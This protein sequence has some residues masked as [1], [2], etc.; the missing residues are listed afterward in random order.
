MKNR[1]LLVLLAVV[2]VVSLIAF[3]ACKAEE[4]APPVEEEGEEVWEWPETL[5]IQT[6]GVESQSYG[7]AV[8]WTT[9]LAED[10]GMRVRVVAETNIV[11]K[12]RYNKEG[13]FFCFARGGEFPPILKA[14]AEFTSRDIG[15]W[16]VRDIYAQAKTDMGYLVRGDSDIKTPYDI[17]PGTRL[18]YFSYIGPRGK[19]AMRA[20]LAW[21]QVDE[22]DVE[23]VPAG[24]YGANYR[25]L[26]EGK[27][28][29]CFGFPSAPITYELE[30]APHGLSW[31]EFDA[32][33]DPE[34]AK[35]YLHYSPE[36]TFGVMTSGVPSCIGV[37][38]FS[39]ISGLSR[40]DDEPEL[41]YHMVKWLDEKYDKYKDTHP[42]CQFMNIDNVMWLA[43]HTYIPLHDGTVRYL[44]EIGRWTP[45]HEARRQQNIDLLTRWVEA[46][47]AA[48]DEA[49]E[50]GIN[51]DPENEEWVELW[52][53]Y[54]DQLPMFANF[55]LGLD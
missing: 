29:I 21:A 32:K 45:A 18:I 3:A 25:L 40:R 52:F 23:W 35:R 48:I 14:E 53:S 2:L 12:Y 39:S 9:P 46:Y 6:H 38:S 31:I 8:G 20:L 55:P 22:E 4:E 16:Q 5:A 26:M 47:Q 43:E 27:G 37:K 44:E 34:A 30:A 1:A 13:R 15:P 54:R 19:D 42:A 50:K 33:A 10:T 28:D 41:V 24:S 7:E 49:D 51:V 11:L 17:K 36:Q